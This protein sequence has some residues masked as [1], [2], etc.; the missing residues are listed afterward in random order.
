MFEKASLKFLKLR[1]GQKMWNDEDICII[2]WHICFWQNE[3]WIDFYDGVMMNIRKSCHLWGLT[4]SWILDI[5]GTWG[6]IRLIIMIGKSMIL[7]DIRRFLPM[8]LRY[9]RQIVRIRMPWN[10]PCLYEQYICCV[11]QQENFQNHIFN[12]NRLTKNVEYAR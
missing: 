2:S 6:P 4:P 5:F 8:I 7:K 10:W 3:I 1:Y 11:G 9:L 12:G